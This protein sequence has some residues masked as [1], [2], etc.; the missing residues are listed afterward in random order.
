[1]DYLLDTHSFLWAVF[2]PKK[3]SKAAR[4]LI[5]RAEHRI[6]I[7]S[8]TFWAI[9]LKCALGRLELVNCLPDDLPDVAN[10]MG[11][12]QV[13]LEAKVA[14]S[15]YRLPRQLHKDPFDRMIIWLAIQKPFILIS[16]DKEFGAYSEYGL[17]TAW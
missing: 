14:A 17:Q 6:F 8:V 16:K 1:M 12:V 5:I 13:G 9:S 4:A 11:I 2:E 10:Q 7:S 3:L 15:F